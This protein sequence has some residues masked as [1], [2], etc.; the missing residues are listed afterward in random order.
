MKRSKNCIKQ[1]V[2][3]K[4]RSKLFREKL[5]YAVTVYF[6]KNIDKEILN[7]WLVSVSSTEVGEETLDL[8]LMY[9][10]SRLEFMHM[11]NNWFWPVWKH[12]LQATA[13][14][15]NHESEA[16]RRAKKVSSTAVDDILPSRPAKTRRAKHQDL[17]TETVTA[18][19]MS[20]RIYYLLV[21]SHQLIFKSYSSLQK[22]CAPTISFRE[23]LQQRFRAET[24]YQL[25]NRTPNVKQNENGTI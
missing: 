24:L 17:F 3:K 2:E 4:D 5:Y 11:E 9:I 23:F 20:P 6:S 19:I 7:F 22:S 25:I 18:T 15:K 10:P 21:F 12:G 1:A 13:I 8:K 16:T 14:N